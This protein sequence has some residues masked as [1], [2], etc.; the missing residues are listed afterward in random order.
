LCYLAALAVGTPYT[1]AKALA[2]A[3]PLL[4]LI[5]LRGLVSA[6]AIEGEESAVPEGGAGRWPPR[7]LRPFVPVAVPLLTVAFVAAAAF[8]TLLPLRQAAVGPD[9]H[10]QEMLQMRPIV[11]GQNVL[12]LGRDN[13]VSWE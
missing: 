4:M 11:D 2:I 3:A 7:M 6:D 9:Y 1:Q 12:F 10:L 8:S 13:F 5:T